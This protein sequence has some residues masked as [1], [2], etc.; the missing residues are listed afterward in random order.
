MAAPPTGSNRITVQQADYANP[1]HANALLMLLQTYALDPAGGA[2]PLSE[3]AQTHLI[4]ALASRP[5]AYSVLAW[6]GTTAVGLVNC[7]E[8]FS[9]FACKPVVN[10]HD[11]VV[12]PSHRGRGVAA[13]MLALAQDL[14]Q[15]RGAVKLTLEVLSGN[16]SA[17]KLYQR[18]GFSSQQLNPEM[19]TAQFMQKHISPALKSI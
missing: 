16:Q 11:V 10:I 12:Q 6:E 3:F 13:L 14:A 5:Q 9:T 2:Q 7:I 15:E 17:C 18:L 1:V 4:A 19:G 8:G